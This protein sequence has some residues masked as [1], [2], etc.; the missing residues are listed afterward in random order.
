MNQYINLHDSAIKLI[1]KNNDTTS[2]NL[3]FGHH[4]DVFDN[5]IAI[6]KSTEQNNVFGENFQKNPN[7]ILLD[8]F[9]ILLNLIQ[10]NE[11]HKDKLTI[12]FNDAIS[13]FINFTEN[14]YVAKCINELI[15]IHGDEAFNVIESYIKNEIDIPK[16]VNSYNYNFLVHLQKQLLNRKIRNQNKYRTII[17]L[18]NVL[19]SHFYQRMG[20]NEIF[21]FLKMKIV[22]LDKYNSA[23]P[24][25]VSLFKELST[26]QKIIENNPDPSN[27][28]MILEKKVKVIE[29]SSKSTFESHQD[30]TKDITETIDLMKKQINNNLIDISNV[31][32]LEKQHIQLMNFLLRILKHRKKKM[33]K[34]KR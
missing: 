20:Q 13:Y 28:I 24:E 4:H 17:Y 1:N 9:T 34:N 30:L 25:S 2:K 18:T 33:S 22:A 32:D 21:V 7:D 6:L 23:F 5:L 10:K 3:L 19:F 27:L 11:V 31:K 29:K 12:T 8:R 15:R 14:K 26:S 16:N